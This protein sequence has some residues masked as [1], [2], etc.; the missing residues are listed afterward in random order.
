MSTIR[1]LLAEDNG[2]AGTAIRD[3]IESVAD[4][5]LAWDAPQREDGVPPAQAMGSL[6]GEN[7]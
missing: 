6:S 2:P 3:V 4:V 5:D 1:A 7:V